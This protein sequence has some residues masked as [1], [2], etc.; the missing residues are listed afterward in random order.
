MATVPTEEEEAGE[1]QEG[2]S[3]AVAWSQERRTE[4]GYVAHGDKLWQSTSR[5]G[6]DE[7]STSKARWREDLSQAVEDD[8]TS[9]GQV[10]EVDGAAV[11]L[12]TELPS[13]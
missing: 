7:A 13:L 6:A 8:Q 3:G 10:D 2:S 5:Q 9:A 1:G 11:S 12:S 4:Q